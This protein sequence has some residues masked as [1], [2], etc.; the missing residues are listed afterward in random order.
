MNIQLLKSYIEYFFKWFGIGL[1]VV[2]GLHLL[3]L[4]ILCF[5]D[6]DYSPLVTG[7]DIVHYASWQRALLLIPYLF[8]PVGIASHRLWVSKLRTQTNKGDEPQAEL[9][10]DTDSD[11]VVSS[12]SDPE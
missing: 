11:S 12:T 4:A 8:I 9:F 6:M 2:F 3:I 7:L 5:I 1:V 10:S